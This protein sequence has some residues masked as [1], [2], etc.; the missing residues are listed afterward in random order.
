MQPVRATRPCIVCFLKSDAASEFTAVHS[1]PN[2]YHCTA[3]HSQDSP[4]ISNLLPKA[5]WVFTAVHNIRILFTWELRDRARRKRWFYVNLKRILDELPPKSWTKVGGS[6]YL[7]DLNHSREFRELLKHFE[8]PELRWCEFEARA[9]PA[10][11]YAR[12]CT[13]K[14]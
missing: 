7:V 4:F 3:V 2:S 11:K 1:F 12:P 6:V 5:R 13:R 8:G 9:P 10:A 14:S